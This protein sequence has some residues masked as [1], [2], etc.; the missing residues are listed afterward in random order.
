[1]KYRVSHIKLL[2]NCLYSYDSLDNF[3]NMKKTIKAFN[4]NINH[5]LEFLIL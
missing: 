5:A 2:K 4:I 3:L 1:M